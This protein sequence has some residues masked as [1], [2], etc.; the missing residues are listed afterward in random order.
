MEM[1]GFA[2]IGAGLEGQAG[3]ISPAL[4]VWGANECIYSYKLLGECKHCD[5][6]TMKLQVFTHYIL[7]RVQVLVIL[8]CI[9]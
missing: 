8:I 6:T 5:R 7:V 1:L 9:M 3:T 2:V 4:H